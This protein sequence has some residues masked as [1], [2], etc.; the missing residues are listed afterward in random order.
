MN[1]FDIHYQTKYGTVKKA[2]G[3]W[4]L[5]PVYEQTSHYKKI[6][7]LRAHLVDCVSGIELQ[8]FRFS[9]RRVVVCNREY[10][11]DIYLLL[12]SFSSK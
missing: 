6:Y 12:A 4:Q 9:P 5:M 10:N 1:L 7:I 2:I 11:I 8:Y 3:Q